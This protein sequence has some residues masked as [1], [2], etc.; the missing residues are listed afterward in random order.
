MTYGLQMSSPRRL[1]A[2][3]LALGLPFAGLVVTSAQAAPAL[4]GPYV[5]DSRPLGGPNGTVLGI[6]H[7]RD[8]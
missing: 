8:D 4:S 6:A 2:V 3:V 7:L 1:S 5:R